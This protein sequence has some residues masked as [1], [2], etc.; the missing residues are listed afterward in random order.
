M[1]A[2]I[3]CMMAGLISCHLTAQP[4][5]TL[6]KL[7][8]KELAVTLKSPGISDYLNGE[9]LNVIVPFSIKND[10]LRVTLKR[11]DAVTGNYRIEEQQ[12]ALQQIGSLGKDG[13]LIFN[14][15]EPV[16][17]RIT[18]YYDGQISNS[19]AMAP[20]CWLYIGIG[21]KSEKLQ[22]KIIELLAKAGYMITKDSLI[23]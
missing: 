4:L 23:D 18:S 11:T 15:K 20:H 1:K 2:W 17:R 14:T 16:Q 13:T 10:T 19:T 21:A 8:N 12:V 6:E 22:Q 5:N 7:L 3:L 9:E